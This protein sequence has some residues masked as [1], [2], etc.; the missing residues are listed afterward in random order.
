MAVKPLRLKRNYPKPTFKEKLWLSRKQRFIRCE[1]HDDKKVT[2][3]YLSLNLD[4]MISG[5]PPRFDVGSETYIVDEQYK[6]T[7]VNGIT[8]LHYTLGIPDPD[9]WGEIQYKE[10]NEETGMNEHRVMGVWQENFMTARKF[11]VRMGDNQAYR[12][13]RGADEEKLQ[14]LVFIVLIISGLNVLFNLIG[15]GGG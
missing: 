4:T 11:K 15:M 7:D 2:K 3:F 13:A 5:D 8:Y 1:F 14:K 9:K 10:H 6:W 12:L